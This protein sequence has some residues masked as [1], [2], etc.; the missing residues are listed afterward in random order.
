MV[1]HSKAE[2]E[3]P[4]CRRAG[5]SEHT[6]VPIDDPDTEIHLFARWEAEHVCSALGLLGFGWL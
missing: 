6:E 3:A 1:V 2:I 4:H 5:V